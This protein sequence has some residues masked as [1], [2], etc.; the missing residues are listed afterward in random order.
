MYFLINASQMNWFL[1]ILIAPLLLLGVVATPNGKCIS[2]IN[3]CSLLCPGVGHLDLTALL[4]EKGAS[5]VFS[6]PEAD[7]EFTIPQCFE[8]KSKS[9]V[10]LEWSIQ[11][12]G[13]H[14]LLVVDI[15]YVG[16]VP[17]PSLTRVVFKS[18]ADP[19]VKIEGDAIV[20]GSPEVP[21]LVSGVYAANDGGKHLSLAA[22]LPFVDLTQ[23]YYNIYYITNPSKSYD[24]YASY[25]NY[26]FNN[27]YYYNHFNHNYYNYYSYYNYYNYYSVNYDLI[28]AEHI[29]SGL[30]VNTI[31]QAIAYS[32][33][34]IVTAN[35]GYVVVYD[36][37]GTSLIE[38]AV[39][40]L[41]N[42][43]GYEDVYNN[44]YIN[45]AIDGS[46]IVVTYIG[47]LCCT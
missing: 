26:Y 1:L 5:R 8:T 25:Q 43:E 45:V 16:T 24:Y 33:N 12:K 21:S 32:N 39:F 13:Y 40:N 28:T 19:Y 27:N 22:D 44:V 20:V 9:S 7:K 18:S 6:L 38:M 31:Y 41:P 47:K 46:L 23:F 15:A 4:T 17:D 35:P 34:T 10:L 2:K 42:R 3:D 36:Y 37:S 29:E 30:I 14:P 11:A